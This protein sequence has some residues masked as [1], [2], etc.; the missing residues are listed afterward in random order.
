MHEFSPPIFAGTRS[1]VSTARDRVI[2]KGVV[3]LSEMEKSFIFKEMLS[4]S[5]EGVN[6][7]HQFTLRVRISQTL[8][9]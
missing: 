8:V 1:P 6:N 3:S 5:C 7:F 4:R 2:E 9:S